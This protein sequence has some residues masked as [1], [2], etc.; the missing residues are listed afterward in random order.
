MGWVLIDF[1]TLNM[2]RGKYDIMYPSACLCNVNHGMALIEWPSH[3][4]YIGV[5]FHSISFLIFCI[6][7]V[8]AYVCICVLKMCTD[9][10]MYIR[11]Y[12]YVCVVKMCVCVCMRIC[13]LKMY[14]F[15]RTYAH[16]CVVKMCVHI[17]TYVCSKCVYMYVSMY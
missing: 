9:L 14:V 1:H 16:I 15:V 11:T 17:R 12:T 8:H 10:R 13:I 4:Q 5:L 2:I 3:S 6:E 7:N